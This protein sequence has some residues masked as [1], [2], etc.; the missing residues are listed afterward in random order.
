MDWREDFS[1]HRPIFLSLHVSSQTEDEKQK[2]VVCSSGISGSKEPTTLYTRGD[3]AVNTQVKGPRMKRWAGIFVM[4]LSMMVVF[5]SFAISAY[6]DRTED[7]KYTETT[8][9]AS[10]GTEDWVGPKE[11][12]PVVTVA[13]PSFETEDWVG[14]KEQGPVVAMKTPSFGTEDWTGTLKSSEALGTGTIP[15]PAPE[16]PNLDDYNPD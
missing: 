7:M 15:E 1:S 6:A 11:Q 16:K 13:A 4:L 5:S 14:P 2:H 10:F 8:G 3:I 9:T 12:G